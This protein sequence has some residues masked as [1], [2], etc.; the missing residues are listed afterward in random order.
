ME[1]M[2]IVFL[3]SLGTA[4]FAIKPWVE[5]VLKVES[6]H[7]EIVKEAAAKLLDALNQTESYLTSGTSS[8]EQE[9]KLVQAWHAAAISLH[10]TSTS[11]SELCYLK[12][13][14]WKSPETMSAEEI[15]TAGFAISQIKEEINDLLKFPSKSTALPHK[16][17]Q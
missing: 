7:T 2:T 5:L 13:D 14:H 10:G 3:G 11:L 4:L 8:K 17:S 1:P 15:A 12:G 9:H 16:T 6:E